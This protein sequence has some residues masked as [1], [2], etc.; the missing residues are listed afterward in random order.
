METAAYLIFGLGALLM[1]S[2][3]ASRITDRLGAP[4]LLVF[5]VIGMLLGE[6]GPG[7]IVFNDIDGAFVLASL[8][9]AVILFD[10]GLRTPRAIFRLGLQPAVVLA[11]VG[12]IVTATVTGAAAM[13]IFDVGPMVGLMIGA[14]VGSTDAAAV[15]YLL[16]AHGLEINERLRATLE[17]ESG[18]NDP[19]AV[20][21]TL[22]VIE[23]LR[24]D[25]VG[26]HWAMLGWFLWQFAGG[27]VFGVLA[28][29]AIASL[30]NRV[31]LTESLYPILVLASGL[32]VFGLAGSLGSSGFLAAYVAGVVVGNRMRRARH[33]VRRFHDGMAWLSQVGLFLMLGLLVTPSEL[34][35]VAL[36]SLALAG[37]LI[38]VARPLAV[39]L[40]LLPFRFSL[41]E[42]AFISWVGLRGAVPIVLGLYPLLAGIAESRTAFNIA[43]F[44][45]LVSLL[46]QGWTVAPAARRL[47]LQ[48]PSRAVGRRLIELDAPGLQGRELVVYRV[49]PQ[50]PAVGFEVRNLPLPADV[51]MMTV[52]RRDEPLAFPENEILTADDHVYLLVWPAELPELEHLFGIE[53]SAGPRPEGFYGTFTLRGDAR[54]V[55]VLA[56]Y[57]VEPPAAYGDHTLDHFLRARF[58]RRV[59]VGDRLGVGHVEL[60]VR[61]VEAGRVVE[62]GLRFRG[63]G[64]GGGL[65]E[66]ANRD[67]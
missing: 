42:Q 43:F 57:G 54:L 32:A 4:L 59:A 37:A 45:V 28:G 29:L 61:E 35:P 20:F 3:L 2:V 30:V 65:A 44:V 55:D 7:G 60:I 19:M 51:R 8:A 66:G 34:I 1:V 5:L 26:S 58:G 14:I 10:G 49:L 9:L 48:L 40:C 6:D 41:R 22:A 11:T 24:A 12:V 64:E 31:T 36:P 63:N 46:V 33:E 13:W 38:L 39:G 18:S 62:V 50:A 47:G 56:L 21:L 27:G 52:V 67:P 23:L 16:H 15:F 17:I 53:R 25:A